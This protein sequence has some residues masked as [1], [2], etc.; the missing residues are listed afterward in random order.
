[1]FSKNEN[2]EVQQDIFE[3]SDDDQTSSSNRA[4]ELQIQEEKS[5]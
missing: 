2:R 5:M 4:Y 3:N 1:M